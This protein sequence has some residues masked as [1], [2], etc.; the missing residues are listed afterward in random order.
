M[1]KGAMCLWKSG[2]VF[3]HSLDFICP[4]WKLSLYSPKG[5]AGDSKYAHKIKKE[6]DMI[7]SVWNCFIEEMIG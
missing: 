5:S 2:S 4:G 3:R 7:N 1:F 6:N